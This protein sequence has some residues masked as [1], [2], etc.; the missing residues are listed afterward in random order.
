MAKLP[1][2]TEFDLVHKQDLDRAAAYARVCGF[3]VR[4]AVPATWL[5]V[6][7][8]GLQGK[9]LRSPEFPFGLA[10]LVHVA[11]EMTLHRPVSVTE[12]LRLAVTAANLRP[13]KRGATFELRGTAHVGDDLVWEGSST[14][15]STKAKVDG[16]PPEAERLRMPEG[17]PSQLWRLPSDLGRQY[18]RVSGDWNPIHLYPLPAKLFGFP[19]H[20]IHG[21][22][23]HARALAAF[24]GA[25]PESYT[26]KVQFTK[27]ILLPS[28]VGFV[29]EGDAFAVVGKDGKPK[30]V[31]AL[32]R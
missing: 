6:C 21:M 15:L 26:A 28:K 23:T 22:W 13:H 14:Y 27:P 8:F 18:A 1:A 11:N 32:H 31:G 24:G 16:E 29:V 30:L 5:H 12:R 25:L 4:D 20:I 9:I 17:E 7:T 3:T 10:G 2:Q 19:R